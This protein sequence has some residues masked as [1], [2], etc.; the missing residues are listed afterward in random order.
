MT[1]TLVFPLDV[2][3]SIYSNITILA[4]SVSYEHVPLTGPLEIVLPL[5]SQSSNQYHLTDIGDY[6][7]YLISSHY[8]NNNPHGLAAELI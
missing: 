5:F 7:A 6:D 2:S 8:R 3:Q 4:H 1:V